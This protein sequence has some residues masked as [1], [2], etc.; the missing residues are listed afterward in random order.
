MNFLD[1]MRPTILNAG[2]CSA[3][4]S[5]FLELEMANFALEKEP[6]NFSIALEREL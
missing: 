2:G 5:E 1:K 3:R 6:K 4:L